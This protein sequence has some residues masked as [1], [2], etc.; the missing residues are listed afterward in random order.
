MTKDIPAILFKT[1]SYSEPSNWESF[2]DDMSS[3]KFSL[4]TIAQQF[5]YPFGGKCCVVR[6]IYYNPACNFE[7][8][9]SFSM[10]LA[11]KLKIDEKELNSKYSLLRRS[12]F[13]T[14]SR[15]SFDL[16]LTSKGGSKQ[17]EY[18][19]VAQLL[20]DT[21]MKVHKIRLSKIVVDFV[22][23]E[24]KTLFLVDVPSYSL[25][26]YEDYIE[27]I[28]G[29]KSAEEKPKLTASE[30]FEDKSALVYCKL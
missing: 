15:N 25:D 3:S 24:N 7:N 30:M 22:Q 21:V 23:D 11:N 5:V 14:S 8:K 9:I 6:F 27:T 20:I 18:E 19:R 13:V 16:Y 1:K 4:N 26:K 28:K 10:N 17:K 2:R 12:T 29:T